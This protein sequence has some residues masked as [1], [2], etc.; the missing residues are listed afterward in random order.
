MGE[1]AA[2]D[3]AMSSGIRTSA[4]MLL[5]MVSG[6]LMICSIPINFSCNIVLVHIICLSYRY[7]QAPLAYP[8]ERERRRKINGEENWLP[9]CMFNDGFMS[10]GSAPCYWSD[11]YSRNEREPENTELAPWVFRLYAK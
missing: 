4:G 6:T 9:L 5:L 1:M 2:Q 7:I 8:R 11:Y 10:D 3:L